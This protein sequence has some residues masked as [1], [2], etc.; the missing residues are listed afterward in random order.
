M[1]RFIKD[2]PLINLFY[3]LMGAKIHSSVVLDAFIQDLDLVN[4]G[5]QTSLQNC[6]NCHKFGKWDRLDGPSL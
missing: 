4:I 3:F 6:L 1:G 5:E 2:T